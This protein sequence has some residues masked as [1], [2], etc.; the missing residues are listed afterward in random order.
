MVEVAEAIVHGGPLRAVA[1]GDGAL[2]GGTEE[3]RRWLKNLT[4]GEMGQ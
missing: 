3:K 2:L 1:I 4:I